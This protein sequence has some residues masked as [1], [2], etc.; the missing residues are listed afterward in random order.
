MPREQMNVRLDDLTRAAI[1]RIA[2][3]YNMSESQVITRGVIL[4]EQSLK[5]ETNVATNVADAPRSTENT[6]PESDTH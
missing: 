3:Q 4:L 2:A 1:K 6:A 5:S